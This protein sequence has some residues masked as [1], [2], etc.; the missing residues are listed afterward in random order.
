MHG[1]RC[2][3]HNIFMPKSRHE[4]QWKVLKIFAQ[5]LGPTKILKLDTGK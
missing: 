5:G 2:G 1:S 3:I 4:E